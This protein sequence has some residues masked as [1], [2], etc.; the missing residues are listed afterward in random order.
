MCF[1]WILKKEIDGENVG[2]LLKE[3]IYLPP[4]LKFQIIYERFG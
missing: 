3:M 1:E 4:K 2:T